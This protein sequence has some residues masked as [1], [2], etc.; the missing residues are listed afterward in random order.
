LESVQKC[1]AEITNNYYGA[2]KMNRKI[3]FLQDF[4]NFFTLIKI[5]LKIDGKSFY[6]FLHDEITIRFSSPF[7]SDPSPSVLL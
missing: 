2:M 7:L 3:A 5:S 4:L 6:E 1:R